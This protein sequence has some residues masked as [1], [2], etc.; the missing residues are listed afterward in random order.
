MGARRRLLQGGW[1]LSGPAQQLL[2]ALVFYRDKLLPQVADPGRAKRAG[3]MVTRCSAA[4]ALLLAQPQMG[5]DGSSLELE[6]L[7][8]SAVMAGLPAFG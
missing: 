3:Y 5:E 8:I 6:D 1:Q 4:L 2:Q 7:G